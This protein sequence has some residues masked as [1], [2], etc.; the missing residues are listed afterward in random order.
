[1]AS[2]DEIK[3]TADKQ[4]DELS[5]AMAALEAKEASLEA[6]VKS[7]TKLQ[8]EAEAKVRSERVQY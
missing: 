5:E 3:Q 7:R 6:T 8:S 4:R 1:M 2:L